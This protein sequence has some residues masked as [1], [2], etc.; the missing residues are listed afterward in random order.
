[1]IIILYGAGNQNL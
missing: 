1:M